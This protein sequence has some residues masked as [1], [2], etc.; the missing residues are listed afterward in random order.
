MLVEGNYRDTTAWMQ[1]NL[2]TDYEGQVEE[3]SQKPR[4][5]T[6]RVTAP[7]KVLTQ[8]VTTEP[9]YITESINA[10]IKQK[11]ITQPT[12][13]NEYI[14]AEPQFIRGQDQNQNRNP[15]YLDTK[16]K[17]ETINKPVNIPGNKINNYTYVQPVSKTIREVV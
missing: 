12:I 10:P 13:L 5:I 3:I 8:R 15:V 2:T 6:Q 7:P 9:K 16:Y 14:K 11:I 1:K 4:I 17:T